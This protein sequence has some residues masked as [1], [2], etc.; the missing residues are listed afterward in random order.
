MP[1]NSGLENDPNGLPFKSSKIQLVSAP[2]AIRAAFARM[3]LRLKQHLLG[4]GLNPNRK[5]NFILDKR[6]G[7][8][9][10]SAGEAQLCVFTNQQSRKSDRGWWMLKDSCFDFARENHSLEVHVIICG[11]FGRG[12]RQQVNQVFRHYHRFEWISW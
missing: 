4:C 10:D 3:Q 11:S 8:F 1:A 12:C 7:Y 5:S 9:L 2:S 6:P